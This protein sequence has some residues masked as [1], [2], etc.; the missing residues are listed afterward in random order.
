MTVTV[1][2][3]CDVVLQPGPAPQ[4]IAEGESVEQETTA[5]DEPDTYFTTLPGQQADFVVNALAQAGI[6]SVLS[7]QGEQRLHGPEIPSAGPFAM[8]LPVEI[9]VPGARLAEV[10]EIVDGLTHDGEIQHAMMVGVD[11]EALAAEHPDPEEP[12]EPI[13]PQDTLAKPS[14]GAPAPERTSSRLLILLGLGILA[15]IWLLAGR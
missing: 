15:V 5:A 8:T 3:E 2:A 14:D 4:E 7:C 1:C 6:F 10:W 13:A 12:V 9:Y 11:V